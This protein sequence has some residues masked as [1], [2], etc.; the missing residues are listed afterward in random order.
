[1][2]LIN[3]ALLLIAL[4]SIWVIPVFAYILFGISLL[5]SFALLTY[6]IYDK[7]K[8]TEHARAKILKNVGVMILTLILIV[9]LGGIAAMLANAQ[10]GGRWGEVA[11]WIS[12]IAASFAVG[13]FVRVGMMRLVG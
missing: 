4:I 13:Y 2:K 3:L 10:V 8:G 11:G 12:A 5:L 1:M 9:F 6:T 7:H